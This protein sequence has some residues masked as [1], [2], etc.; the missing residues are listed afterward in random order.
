MK[1]YIFL[2]RDIEDHWIF[3]EPRRF[4]WWLQLLFM[5]AWEPKTVAFGNETV[6]LKRGQI[7]T[8]IRSLMAR[9][10]VCSQAALKFLDLLETEAMITRVSTSKFTFI[11][12]VNYDKYQT[13]IDE[14]LE[15]A[16]RKSKRK[17]KQTK[18]ENNESIKKEENNTLYSLTR[19][20]A[21]LIFENLRAD[22]DKVRQYADVFKIST[23]EMTLWLDRFLA[24]LGRR[25]KDY[26]DEKDLHDHFKNWYEKVKGKEGAG[27]KNENYIS[28]T[29]NQSYNVTTSAD[30]RR[31]VSPTPKPSNGGTK[32]RF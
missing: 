25:V 32:G 4:Q 1:G 12:V 7:A 30:R 21:I 14:I 19:E 28:S 17:S 31:G 16:K 6:T 8:T 10:K 29:N 23:E 27:S 18:E 20:N 5:A 11:T 24:R 9:W 26:R 22:A 15:N 3:N 2:Y 13:G